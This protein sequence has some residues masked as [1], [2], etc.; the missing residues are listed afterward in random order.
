[1]IIKI[2]NYTPDQ[3]RRRTFLLGRLAEE[4]RNFE[5]RVAYLHKA[6]AIIEEHHVPRYEIIQGPDA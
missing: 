2:D 3:Q 5:E 1:M 6:L 4:T